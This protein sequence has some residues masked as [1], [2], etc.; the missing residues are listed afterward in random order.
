M[1][2]ERE[3]SVEASSYNED[4]MGEDDGGELFPQR[5]TS[6]WWTGS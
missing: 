5:I 2:S 3:V 1:A 6:I 4:M